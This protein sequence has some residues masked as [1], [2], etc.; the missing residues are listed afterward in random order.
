MDAKGYVRLA[1]HLKMHDNFTSKVSKLQSSLIDGEETSLE[2]LIFLS[3]W[4]TNHILVADADFAGGRK[5][6]IDNYPNLH[7]SR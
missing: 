6:R 1:E 7:R 4:L 3:D 5:K 2:T